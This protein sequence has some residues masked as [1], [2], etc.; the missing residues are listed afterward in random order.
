MRNLIWAGALVFVVGC[1]PRYS[2]REVRD[3]REAIKIAEEEGFDTTRQREH[4]AEMV[5]SY[6]D[7]PGLDAQDQAMRQMALSQAAMAFNSNPYFQ[8]QPQAMPLSPMEYQR[9]VTG[10]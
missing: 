9:A 2:I 1:A 6:M 5:D 7:N 4:L 3:Y 10:R 8:P